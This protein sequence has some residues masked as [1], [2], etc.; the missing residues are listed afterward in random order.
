MACSDDD[1][2][3][4]MPPHSAPKLATEDGRSRLL[5]WL[6]DV[7]SELGV[8]RRA[9]VANGDGGFT[10]MTEPSKLSRG[11]ARCKCLFLAHQLLVFFAPSRYREVKIACSCSEVFL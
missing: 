4:V 10:W 2:L 8:D 11:V 6:A 3:Y 1:P 7:L 5:K 9:R